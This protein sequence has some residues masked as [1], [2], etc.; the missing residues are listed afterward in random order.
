MENIKYTRDGKKVVVIGDLNQTEKIVQEI[1]V[2]KE[3]DEIPSGERFIV[4]SLLDEPAKSWKEIKLEQIEKDYTTKKCEWELKIKSLNEEKNREYKLLESEVKWL[5]NVAKQPLEQQI[6]DIINTLT[7]FMSNKPK[8]VFTDGWDWNIRELNK[9]LE[10]DDDGDVRFRLLSLYGNSEGEITWRTNRWWN[11]DG[12][13]SDGMQ[14]FD[15][16]NKAIL[17]AQ[18]YLDTMDEY[19]DNDIKKAKKFGL[20]LDDKKLKSK[21]T[22]DKRNIKYNI[23]KYEKEIAKFKKEL[24]DLEN[25]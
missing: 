10:L 17:Y 1:F 6:K 15:D 19:R 24:Y 21:K 11:G 4:K 23:S 14:F 16:Y 5:R 9:E 2:T 20:K 13:E 25:N 22:S 8:W 12:S 18:K 7:I 3:G